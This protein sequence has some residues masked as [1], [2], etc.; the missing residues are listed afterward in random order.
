MPRSSALPVLAALS[1][2]LVA[3]TASAQGVAKDSSGESSPPPR[4]ASGLTAGSLRYT[5][6]R[7]EEAASAVLKVRLSHGLFASIEPTVARATEPAAGVY[8][9]AS[10]TGLTDIP[11]A[12][13]FER[14][15]GGLLSPTLGLSLGATL[16]VGNTATGFGT[17]V[18]GTSIDVGGGVSP[19]EELSLYAGAGKTLSNVTAQSAFNGGASGWADLGVTF[20]TTDRLAL[21]GG[22]AT[23][24]GAIDTAYGR[25]RSLSAGV[26]YA[27][28][29]PLALNIQTSHGLG[30]ATPRW[31]AVVGIGTAFGALEGA[32]ELRNAFGG[33]R[34]GLSKKGSGSSSSGR[35]RG[36]A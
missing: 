35:G 32:R 36:H 16:P 33:G 14:E 13:E 18:V 19:T 17:G 22:F 25:G 24:L 34:H 15:L 12:L 31:S 8:P 26:S 28:A 29:G 30:G 10:N 9:A 1:L 27:L 7:A 4:L 11:V 5:G 21:L 6:G 3:S 23:D 20:Q 2:L